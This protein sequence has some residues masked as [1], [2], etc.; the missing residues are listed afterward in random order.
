MLG[1]HGSDDRL[2][3]CGMSEDPCDCD[4][5]LGYAFSLCKLS[6]SFVKLGELGI[7]DEGSSEH[8]ELKR[9]PCLNGDVLQSAVIKNIAVTVY[10]KLSGLV[11]HVKS[12]IDKLALLK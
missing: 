12:L 8:S 7:S 5:R 3:L 9:R 1:I 6:E 2:H 4:R 10:L 11:V